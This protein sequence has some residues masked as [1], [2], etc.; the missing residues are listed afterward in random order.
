MM[1]LVAKELSDFSL[2]FEITPK[3]GVHPY[4]FPAWITAFGQPFC[5]RQMCDVTC[6]F[7]IKFICIN[8]S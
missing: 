4:T 8:F 7:P 6:N 5:S 2:V 3:V 1:I